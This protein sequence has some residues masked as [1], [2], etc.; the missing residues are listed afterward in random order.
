[1]GRDEVTVAEWTRVM[2]A[3][4]ARYGTPAQNTPVENVSWFE[5]QEFCKRLCE[6]EGV[7]V[8]TYR[9]PTESEWEYACRAGT[10][11]RFHVGDELTR[12]QACFGKAAYLDRPGPMPVGSFPA[13][14]WG[15]RDMHGNVWEWCL[16]WYA[17]DY[18]GTGVD[19]RGPAEG[20]L[21]ACRGGG[22]G[23]D[24]NYCR[25]ANRNNEAAPDARCAWIGFRVVRVIVE[26]GGR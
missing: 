22:W 7:R 5:V 24:A 1:M 2:S 17:E 18:S 15:L 11:T 10:T 13:N 19:D 21:K 9:L 16:D 8:G 14:A 6:L 3:S 25:S 26:Q 23:I 20:S 4:P 12:A